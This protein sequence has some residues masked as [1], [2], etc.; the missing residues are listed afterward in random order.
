VATKHY[1][2]KYG[3]D[4]IAIRFGKVYGAPWKG[5][6]LFPMGGSTVITDELIVKPAFGKPGR[7]P[8]GDA[9]LNWLDV[10]GAARSVMMASSATTKTRAFNIN[11]DI[12]PMTE[13]VAHVRKLIPNAWI[14]VLPGLAD[15]IG[16]AVK[17]DA[18]RAK[19][20]IGYEPRWK[21]EDGIQKVIEE[22]RQ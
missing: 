14:T 2:G 12:R 15:S 18:T 7:V 16:R 10:E 9:T 3:V 19:E 11:G 17:Y 8:S 21:M 22:V 4:S 1:F 6:S 5:G 20:E 13:A